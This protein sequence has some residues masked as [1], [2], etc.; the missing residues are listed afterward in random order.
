[1]TAGGS[2][3]TNVEEAGSE[4]VRMCLGKGPMDAG[5]M[6]TDFPKEIPAKSALGKRTVTS[7]SPLSSRDLS[8][9]SSTTMM[10]TTFDKQD[11]EIHSVNEYLRSNSKWPIKNYLQVTF[12]SSSKLGIQKNNNYAERQCFVNVQRGKKKR[13][14]SN[15]ANL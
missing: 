1:M 12:V 2:L 15:K 11:H 13:Y 7:V 3:L 4:R 10:F 5:G 8:A 9:I 6:L 14:S